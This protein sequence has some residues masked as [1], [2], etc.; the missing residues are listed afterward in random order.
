MSLLFTLLSKLV[1]LGFSRP[2]ATM[3][4]L[5]EMTSVCSEFKIK[6]LQIRCEILVVTAARQVK[7]TKTPS[8]FNTYRLPQQEPSNEEM[9]LTNILKIH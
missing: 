3:S 2:T 5:V 4:S 9:F 1:L 8:C 7:A 6:L